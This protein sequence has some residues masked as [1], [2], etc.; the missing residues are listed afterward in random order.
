MLGLPMF[1]QV[2]DCNK[3]VIDEIGRNRGITV[4]D[5][6]TELQNE[7]LLGLGQTPHPDSIVTTS[8]YKP[9]AILTDIDRPYGFSIPE[10]LDL[11][12]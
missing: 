9:V 6:C 8:R 2:R 3:L 1:N 11:P 7:L 5:K 12:V 4:E 10:R